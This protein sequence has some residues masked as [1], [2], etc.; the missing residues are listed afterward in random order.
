MD[1]FCFVVRCLGPPVLAQ[2]QDLLVGLAKGL[3][4]WDHFAQQHPHDQRDQGQPNEFKEHLCRFDGHG[5][6]KNLRH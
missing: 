5:G 6:L 2:A 1:N 4:C 3:G